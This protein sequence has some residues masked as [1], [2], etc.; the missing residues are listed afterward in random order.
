[1]SVA[2]K[3]YERPNRQGNPITE[4]VDR[5]IASMTGTWFTDD[6]AEDT[7]KDLMFHDLLC[8]E[9]DGQAA[10]FIVFTSTE[11]SIA[12]TLMGTEPSH[13]RK[14]YGSVL[15]QHLFEHVKGMGFTT[16]FAL[17][18]P[19]RSKPAY[20]QTVDFYKKHGFQIKQEYTELWQGGTIKLVKVLSDE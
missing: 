3:L 2:V 10:S 19:P 5:I 7:R 8:L 17:T 20:Q 18:V 9:I 16:I 1:M 6:V 14:G 15:L 4:Q 11:S 12:I 13:H